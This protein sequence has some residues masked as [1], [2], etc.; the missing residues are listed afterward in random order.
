M[1]NRTAGKEYRDSDIPAE[2]T[3]ARQDRY[4]TEA[5]QQ[6]RRQLPVCVPNSGYSL[7]RTISYNL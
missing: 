3:E 7:Y 2:L 4:F 6:Q 5:R 1:L